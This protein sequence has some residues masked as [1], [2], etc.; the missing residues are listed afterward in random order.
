[1]DKLAIIQVVMTA[2]LLVAH[3]TVVVRNRFNQ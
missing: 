1:M 3:L 2:A